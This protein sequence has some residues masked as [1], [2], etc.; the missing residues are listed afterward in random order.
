M[1]DWSSVR[2]QL[3]GERDSHEF[4]PEIQLPAL[5]QAVR[6]FCEESRDV[7]TTAQRLGDIIATD[8]GLTG[9]LLKL[10]N[11]SSFALRCKVSSPKQAISLLGVKACRL[12]LLT[13]A[14]QQA[15]EAVQS[16]L[17]NARSFWSVNLERGIFAREVARLLGAD[18]ELAYAAGM[19]QDCL[20]PVLTREKLDDYLQFGERR[21]PGAPTLVEQEEDRF[22]WNH[23][24]AAGHLLL[25]WDF[26]DELVCCIW[27]HHRGLELLRDPE[28]GRT[29]AAAV[30]LSA[31]L[32]DP[33]HQM[34]DGVRQLICLE[35]AWPSF[36]LE[37]LARRVD[38]EM[39]KQQNGCSGHIS[40][41]RRCQAMRDRLE[42][43]MAEA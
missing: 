28:A 25:A 17:I 3:V 39:A 30:A 35:R 16:K 22:G 18:V 15:A 21:R 11:S 32:P 7:S 8:A 20:L 13:T 36:R 6:E 40:L 10:L 37:E 29:A 1:T 19:L 33:L 2:R 12:F 23:C 27:L 42:A 38:E 4:P 24:D 41:S 34:P 5:P 9:S 26:P 31:L 43:A 14:A